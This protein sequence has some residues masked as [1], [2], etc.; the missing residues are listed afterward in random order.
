MLIGIIGTRGIPNNYGGFEQFAQQLS[1]GLVRKGHAVWVYNSSLH[2]YTEDLYNGVHII[3]CCDA[4]NWLGT[5]GQFIY[6]RNCL[7][8]ARNRG[9][10]ILLHL[11]YTSDSI[12]YRKWRSPAIHIVNMDGMEWKRSKYNWL[13]RKF[14]KKAES[15]AVK[16]ADILI[17]DS[18]GI[19]EHLQTTYNHQSEFIPYGAIGFESPDSSQLSAFLL[20]PGA[21]GILVAR[22]EPENNIEMI[23]RGWIQ[24]GSDQPL[25]V[26]GDTGNNFG[27]RMRR[28]YDHPKI[29]FAGSI[30]DQSLLNNLRYHSRYYFHGHS[31][32]GTNPSLLEAMACQC[33]ILAHDNIFNRSVLGTDASFFSTEEDL[34]E[35][36]INQQSEAIINENKKKNLQ[37]IKENYNWERIISKY[38]SVMLST[39]QKR[40]KG[41]ANSVS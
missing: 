38:E 1:A 35:L 14:L 29:R 24:S 11:G 2:P 39:L 40:E 28:K 41:L 30:Y 22:M 36:L 17:A 6:D 18:L 3:H 27:K 5:A 10:D 32:G 15:L 31:A 25:L 20:E 7:N 34:T 23:I 8:D 26:V 13:T 21:Y 9:F 4:E 12:F 16:H 19:K 33:N 37:K